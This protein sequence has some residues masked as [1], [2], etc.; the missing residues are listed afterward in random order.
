MT[1]PAT[2]SHYV[3][4]GGG[5]AGCIVA[6][7]LSED[8][9]V[10][11]TLVEP[12]PSD[13]NEPRALDIRRWPDMVES[14]Y[15]LDYRS[16]PQERGNSHIRQARM[17]ILGGCSTANTMITWRPLAADL[18]EWAALGV[19]GWDSDVLNPYFDGLATPINPVDAKDQNPYL[20]DVVDAARQALDL[21]ARSRWN[22][23]PDFATTGQGAG[24]F[25]I[26]YT[27]ES[28][29]RSSTSV[30]YVHGVVGERDNLEVLHGLAAIRVLLEDG[31]AV[32]VLVRDADGAEREIRATREVVL[33]CGAVDTPKLLQLSGIGP[34][35]MLVDA[36]VDVVVDL[37]GVGENLMDH[38]EGLIVWEARRDV[39][40]T[41]A[42][43]W[44]AGAAV[45]LHDGEPARP[46]VLMHFPVEAWAVHAVTYGVTLP[47]RIVAIAPNVAKPKSRGR[48][49]I[50]SS[51]PGQAPSIDYGYFTD[52]DGADEATLIAGIR[53][54]RRV[55]A[56]S[57]MSEWIGREVFP[58]AEL[59][60]DEEL[61]PPLR[62]T[63]QTVYHVS[64]T[65]RMGAADD[66]MA[67]LDSH[68][69]VRGVVGLRVVDASVFPTI[70]S[71]N[72]VGT[73]MTVAERA[74]VLIA[75]DGAREK[76]TEDAAERV[77]VT[78]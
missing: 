19:E 17:R 28:H 57:P 18:D 76:P 23:D 10:T 30:H 26:G 9:G 69:R 15:D 34:S 4:V 50:T 21:P 44:D 33:C 77:T 60:T 37:P 36:G 63:H 53:L 55:A 65:C 75:A 24:F 72:P 35:R 68:L 46:D 32:G 3:V 8:P 40:D 1:A 42:T 14:E 27:P 5:T 2:Q 38:A 70:P 67:V 22:S 74:A 41:C 13:A 59:T 31:A 61:S 73:V 25:E 43:G 52:P 54:A 51:D 56:A 58:G 20:A 45:K 48:V 11:V 78:T 49:W 71:V 12:G 39:P 29:L 66:P 16:V 7:R 62:A 47:D 64:G 6:A